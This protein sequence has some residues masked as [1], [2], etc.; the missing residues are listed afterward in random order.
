MSFGSFFATIPKMSGSIPK[1]HKI[2]VFTNSEKK[3]YS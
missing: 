3:R 2:F 1:C